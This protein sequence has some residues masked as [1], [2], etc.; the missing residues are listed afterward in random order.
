MQPGALLASMAQF[1]IFE[2]CQRGGWCLGFAAA[3]DDYAGFLPRVKQLVEEEGVD[4]NGRDKENITPLHWAAINNKLDIIEYVQ[5][6]S[7]SY[8][9]M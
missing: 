8:G 3:V 5:C 4:V 1:N 9:L 2:S 6:V 7:E